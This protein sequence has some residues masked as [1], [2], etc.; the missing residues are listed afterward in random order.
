MLALNRTTGNMLGLSNS[1]WLLLVS[2][3][4]YVSIRKRKR[5]SIAHIRGPVPESFLL[6][7]LRQLLAGTL[8]NDALH[9]L[10]TYG[11][12]ARVRAP[13]GEDRLW[14][15]DPA[16]IQ[17]ILSKAR[18]VWIK[19]HEARW[20]LIVASGGGVTGME[21]EEHR[22]QRRA[23]ARAFGAG[24]VK[25]LESGLKERADVLVRHIMEKDIGHDRR[26]G[27]EF[28]VTELLSRGMLD[29]VGH[30]LSGYEFHALEGNQD[31]LAES[32]HGFMAK[33]F[34]RPDSP[35]LFMHGMMAHI[36]MS[37]LDLLRYLPDPG[38]AFLRRHVRLSNTLS[39]RLIAERTEGAKRGLALGTDA[40]SLIVKANIEETGRWRLRDEELVPQ[41]ATLLAAGHET[42]LTTISWILYELA[43]H[44]DV[45]RDLRAEIE[46]DPNAD[47]DSLTLLNAVIKE[48][49]RFDTVVPYLSRVATQ[50][51]VIPL[52]KP[53]RT[54]EGEE[55]SEV[56]VPKDT[57]VFVSSIG[58]SLNENV[59]G[60]DANVW[61]PARW[62]DETIARTQMENI[63]PYENLMSFGAGHRACVGWR[64]AITELQIFLSAL[65]RALEFRATARTRAVRRENCLVMLPIVEG[66]GNENRMPLQY[67]ESCDHV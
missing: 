67:L 23:V 55:I 16:A 52:S 44:E 13:L 25:A 66:E 18:D 45:Q 2:A 64:Y 49:M 42:T 37:L 17:H 27:V 56:L 65:I 4:L 6:G 21:G 31:E 35:K 46:L 51:D 32:L 54:S 22:R 36:P 11:S 9:I 39:R 38:L 33:G 26:D 47:L 58:Y 61:R 29:A 62:M 63:G 3:A 41:F 59:W 12:L 60:T 1:V 34:G 57:R 10:Q 50:D 30:A 48:T 5:I 8:P 14:T 53:I 40:L 19:P 43:L 24:E 7:N 20:A 28:D 15:A